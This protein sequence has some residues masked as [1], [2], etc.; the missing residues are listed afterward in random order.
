MCR[1]QL[2][3]TCRL[4]RDPFSGGPESA[5]RAAS[6]SV[7]KRLALVAV[8]PALR[9]VLRRRR[10]PANVNACSLRGFPLVCSARA[11]RNSSLPDPLCQSRA[12]GV[13]HEASSA[14]KLSAVSDTPHL[15][16]RAAL[17]A[18]KSS[19]VPPASVVVGVDHPVAAVS[20]VRR[21]D[22][23]RRERDGPE[24]V[25]QGF[26]VSAYKVDPR[27]DSLCRN[28]LSKDDCR[29][30]L[31][32]EVVPGRP[33]VPLVSK[34]SAFA[35]RA[36]RLTRARPSPNR[37]IVWPSCKTKSSGPDPDAGEEV[38][39]GVAVDLMGFDVFDA[40]LVDHAR[41]DVAR[42]D[43]VAEPLRGVGVDL[44]VERRHQK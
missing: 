31:A 21:A 29:A 28:L 4:D 22:A 38:A 11:A 35:S 36:E 43:Q 13:A 5:E 24:S 26:H 7:M 20:D 14:C 40:S 6:V 1:V 25:A 2:A 12:A 9:A 19:G 39:L 33:E 23:R 17:R 15:P 3:A 41:C 44:V 18:R 34:S 8:G 32:D 30:A 10:R 16:F 27:V 37:S 42:C